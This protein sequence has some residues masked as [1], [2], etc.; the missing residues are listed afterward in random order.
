MKLAVWSMSQ[1]V[2][3][4]AVHTAAGSVVLLATS[5]VQYCRA[6]TLSGLRADGKSTD[7]NYVALLRTIQRAV[8]VVLTARHAVRY[9]CRRASLR[10]RRDAGRRDVI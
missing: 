6:L 10:S 7:A 5:A 2:S 8:P 3:L 1:L 9:A 4:C